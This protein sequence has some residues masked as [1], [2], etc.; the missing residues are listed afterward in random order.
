MP[1]SC[2]PI[3][4]FNDIVE[5][6]MRLGDWARAAK[7]AGLDGIDVSMAFIH[8]HAPVYLRELREQVDSEGMRIIM[9]TTYPDFT[10]TDPIQRKREHDYLVRDIAV[11]SQL[12]ITYLRV[13]AGQAHPGVSRAD[14]VAYAV[15]GLLSC[16]AAAKAYGVQLV[17]EDHAKPSAWDYVDFS[18]PP[19]LFLQIAGQLRGTSI[20]VNFDTGN[21]TAYGEDPRVILPQVIDM[22]KTVHVSDMRESGTFSPV[23]IGEGATPLRDL[24]RQL[25]EHGFDG[26][27]CIEEAS[28]MGMEGICRAVAN[29]RRLWQE[30]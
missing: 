23:L 12:R 8:S 16:E 18:Y 4:L 24:F 22:V 30:A 7:E 20:G 17:Y 6:R 14:G 3:S 13:L 15:E 11:C 21:I 9:A 19:E 25:K 27:L 2:L 1:F 29:T 5:G 10:C 26:W 28:G